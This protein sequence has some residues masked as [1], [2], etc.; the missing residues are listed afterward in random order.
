MPIQNNDAIKLQFTVT[1]KDGQN[2][3]ISEDGTIRYVHGQGQLPAKIETALTGKEL[4]DSISLSLSPEEAYGA[5]K[6]ELVQTLS[7]EQFEE[8]L[9]IYVGMTFQRE[10]EK[11]PEIV[12]VTK[13]E[14]NIITA[15]ANHPLAG[16]DLNFDIKI[17]AILPPVES[18]KDPEIQFMKPGGG[19]S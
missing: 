4:N 10:T 16:I 18:N 14:N 1:S 6:D 3:P 11:G 9:K 8:G 5:H 2:I 12:R 15:D 7:P 17:L 19:C 13:V